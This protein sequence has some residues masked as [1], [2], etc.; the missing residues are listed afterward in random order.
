MDWIQ[1]LIGAVALYGACLSTYSVFLER[2]ARRRRRRASIHA[3]SEAL[4][5][6]IDT[7]PQIP[8]DAR[9]ASDFQITWSAEDV[10]ALEELGAEEGGRLQQLT[11]LA[12]EDLRWLTD[13]VTRLQFEELDRGLPSQPWQ[14]HRRQGREALVAIEWESS[15]RAS[16]WLDALGSPIPERSKW[17]ERIA[18]RK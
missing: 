1:V 4:L 3:I 17:W 10:R 11:Q 13:T 18:F 15:G 5:R 14:H 9:H 16:G 2:R 12:C 7:I 8:S 6:S